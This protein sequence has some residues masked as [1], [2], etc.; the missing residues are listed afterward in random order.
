[1]GPT[2]RASDT[3]ALA[4]RLKAHLHKTFGDRL[5]GVVLYGSEARRE[6]G[7]ESDIDLLVLLTGPVA[8]GQDLWTCIDALYPVHLDIG[9]PIHAL[10]V[11]VKVYEK[12]EFGL[13]RNARQQGVLV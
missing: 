10:P 13:Y 3:Q 8:L 5:R 4:N 6:A 11:D 7:P 12:G 1:M 9:R 2:P